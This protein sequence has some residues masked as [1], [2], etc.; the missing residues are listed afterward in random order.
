M[1]SVTLTILY[2][3]LV[4]IQHFLSSRNNLLLGGIV[5]SIYI[6]YFLRIYLKEGI[7]GFAVIFIILGFL[8][9]LLLWYEGRS[10]LKERRKKELEKMKTIDMK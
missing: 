10:N 8:F 9:L 7:S 6:I 2:F 1:N 4:G 3:S 5:P